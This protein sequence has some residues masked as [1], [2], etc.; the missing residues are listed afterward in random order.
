MIVYLTMADIAERLE[1]SHGWLRQLRL[2][3]RL[4]DP[5]AKIGPRVGWLP[6]TIAKWQEE[7]PDGPPVDVSPEAG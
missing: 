4:P 6:E 1:M 7:H 3:G 2:Q 5:D